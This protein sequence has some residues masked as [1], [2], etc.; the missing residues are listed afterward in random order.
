MS[1]AVPA[2]SHSRECFSFGIVCNLKYVYIVAFI[3]RYSEEKEMA[4]HRRS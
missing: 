3:L 2:G 1:F 4:S